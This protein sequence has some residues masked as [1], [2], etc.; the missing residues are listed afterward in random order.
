[1]LFQ[2]HFYEN[3]YK[4]MHSMRIILFLLIQMEFS[5]LYYSVHAEAKKG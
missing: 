2:K 3:F 5:M 4:T 1:M